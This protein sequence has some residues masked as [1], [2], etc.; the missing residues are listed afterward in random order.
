MASIGRDSSIEHDT[1]RSYTVQGRKGT[2]ESTAHLNLPRS[3]ARNRRSVAARSPL[4]HADLSAASLTYLQN[5]TDD[6]LLKTRSRYRAHWVKDDDSNADIIAFCSRRMD[7]EK[8]V[9]PQSRRDRMPDFVWSASE[10]S[11][12]IRQQ[13]I[14]ILSDF[15]TDQFLLD[16][17]YHCLFLLRHILRIENDEPS[18]SPLTLMLLLLLLLF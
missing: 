8:P 7:T 14:Q 17:F 5:A 1:G 12:D 11:R 9:I 4:A 13:T 18:P 2:L 15:A 10:R 16:T 3:F 6:I